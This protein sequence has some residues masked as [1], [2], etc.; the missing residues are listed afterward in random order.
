M[1]SDTSSG[2]LSIKVR[3]KNS[4]AGLQVLIA[5]IASVNKSLSELPPITL[6]KRNIEEG[7]VR[8]S[9]ADMTLKFPDAMEAR[10]EAAGP[11]PTEDSS[12]NGI[13][14]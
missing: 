2:S 11:Y 3:H 10:H 13:I 6:R 7:R 8:M 12:Q 4:S 9:K 5:G 1:E 14:I